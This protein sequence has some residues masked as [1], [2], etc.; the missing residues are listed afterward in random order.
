MVKRA[1][2]AKAKKARK[3]KAKKAASR[4]TEVKDA[5]DRYAN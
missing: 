4:R 1:K 5:H 2:K 3:V